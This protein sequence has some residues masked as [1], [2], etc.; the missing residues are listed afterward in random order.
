MQ[1]GAD[2][3]C[4]LEARRSPAG[5]SGAPVPGCCVQKTSNM[6]TV[7][8]LVAAVFRPASHFQSLYS[9]FGV[10]ILH[11]CLLSF[12]RMPILGPKIF[13]FA[14]TNLV[15]VLI[16]DVF[17][18]RH[19]NRPP[20]KPCTYAGLS[21]KHARSVFSSASCLFRRAST[22]FWYRLPIRW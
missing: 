2:H 8:N 9:L 1:V 6:S 17:C 5:S 16:F 3:S 4:P 18:T 7:T 10:S 14:A 19:I 21:P 11:I 13:D 22:R 20:I 15:A 12:Q